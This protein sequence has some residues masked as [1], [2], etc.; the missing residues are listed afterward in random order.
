MHAVVSIMENGG[1]KLVRMRSLSADNV[2]TNG[3]AKTADDVTVCFSPNNNGAYDN[4]ITLD[5][6][7]ESVVHSVISNQVDIVWRNLSYDLEQN[8][9]IRVYNKFFGESQSGAKVRNIL[10]PQHGL[11]AGRTLTA[12]MGPSGAGK[13]TLLNCITSKI[14]TGVKGESFIRVPK[15]HSLR[16]LRIGFVPQHDHL[17]KPFTIRES[18]MFASRMNNPKEFNM[19]DHKEKV[20]EILDLL[21]LTT[22]ADQR[23]AHLSGGQVKRTSIGLEFIS[24]PAMLILDEPTSGLDS[25]NAENVIRLLKRLS[26]ESSTAII[27]TIHQPSTAVLEMF[28]F[29]YMLN[30]N[31][32]NIYYGPPN[33]LNDFFVSIGFERPSDRVN[34]ADF[35]M[36]ICNARYG[37][38]KFALMSSIM[39]Q[40]MEDSIAFQKQDN[41]VSSETVKKSIATSGL[42]QFG[43]LLQRSIQAVATKSP[44]LMIRMLLSILMSVGIC[45]LFEEPI[46][47]ADGCW[48]QGNASSNGTVDELEALF[49]STKPEG[50]SVRLDFVKRSGKLTTNATYMFLQLMYVMVVHLIG[51]A[52]V[53]PLEIE[54]VSKEMANSWYGPA[55]YYIAKIV[56]DTFTIL[57][58]NTLGHSYIYWATGQI[59]VWW[60]FFAYYFIAMIFGLVCDAIGVIVGIVFSFDIITAIFMATMVTFP[61]AALSGLMVRLNDIPEYLRYFAYLSP[62]KYCFEGALLS[63]Y[64]FGRC[65]GG[66]KL[67]ELFASLLTN[68]DPILLFRT[69]FEKVDLTLTTMRRF[70]SYINLDDEKYLDPVYYKMRELMGIHNDTEVVEETTDFSVDYDNVTDGMVTEEVPA[71]RYQPSFILSFFDMYEDIFYQS[72]Y[73]LLI[74]M[75]IYRTI[76]Y[77]ALKR[78]IRNRRL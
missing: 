53:L 59:R 31:G 11:I 44:Q 24:S 20:Q 7:E 55:P 39:Q 15:V 34:P 49:A 64:G 30:L 46:G 22:C 47:E 28:D 35:G 73:A 48:T 43:M 63:I 76:G 58:A 75:V 61:I 42:F 38:E 6:D 10:K 27:T 52:V 17:F 3:Q 23:I 60:R 72:F 32:E 37:S 50:G 5:E 13:T 56:T 62:L 25:D 26:R 4:A 67:Q 1:L 18:L 40:R 33:E 9:F 36:E 66:E 69:I 41:E 78:N 14:V 74:M 57:M 8:I 45:L 16:N 68:S 2:F 65:V 51:T 12:L 71:E 77:F 70:A 54:I 19:E 21:N 29:I